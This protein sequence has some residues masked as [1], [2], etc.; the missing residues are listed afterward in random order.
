MLPS[1]AFLVSCSDSEETVTS[2]DE[3]CIP[4]RSLLTTAMRDREQQRASLLLRGGICALLAKGELRSIDMSNKYPHAVRTAKKRTKIDSAA[5]TTVPFTEGKKRDRE[6]VVHCHPF[7]HRVLS[8][9]WIIETISDP[10]G[11]SPTN[12]SPPCVVS[13]VGDGSSQLHDHR[14]SNEPMSPFV[15]KEVHNCSTPMW[16][17]AALVLQDHDDAHP[18]CLIES[19]DSGI[20]IHIDGNDDDCLKS[21]PPP[22]K[23]RQRSSGKHGSTSRY[24]KCVTDEVHP[25]GTSS[26]DSSPTYQLFGYSTTMPSKYRLGNSN[27][28]TPLVDSILE[29][30]HSAS[31][32]TTSFPKDLDP[33]ATNLFPLTPSWEDASPLRRTVLSLVNALG[34]E[35]VLEAGEPSVLD[36][37]QRSFLASIPMDGGT[38]DLTNMVD[39]LFGS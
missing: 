38:W 22:R 20:R 23:Q 14:R 3:I 39:D 2:L 24:K 35:S 33:V 10:P 27:S 7:F 30:S 34:E 9:E 18:P 19:E 16:R 26:L 5:T 17:A 8:D 25:C 4:R 12:S 31:K 21:S 36:A 13:V 6:E 29:G 11:G 37:S 1:H 28:K 15:Q 32:P